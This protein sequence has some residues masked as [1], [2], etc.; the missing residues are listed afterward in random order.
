[1]VMGI[2]LPDSRL[3]QP[4]VSKSVGVSVGSKTSV[5]VSS[6][7]GGQLKKENGLIN[8]EASPARCK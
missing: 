7:A 8:N 3:T 5:G 1:M 6:T 2:Y 4:I